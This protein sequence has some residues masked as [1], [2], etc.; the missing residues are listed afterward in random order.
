M[1]FDQIEQHDITILG[2]PRTDPRFVR[3]MEL[4]RSRTRHE[5]RDAID[6][7]IQARDA[8]HSNGVPSEG[9]QFADGRTMRRLMRFVETQIL[10]YMRAGGGATCSNAFDRDECTKLR[11]LI[12][13]AKALSSTMQT[14]NRR[15]MGIIWRL[16]RPCRWPMF[17]GTLLIFMAETAAAAVVVSSMQ[18]PYIADMAGTRA[19]V[20]AHAYQRCLSHFVLWAFQR[21]AAVI[22]NMLVTHA[23]ANFLMRLRNS[24]MR[25]ILSQDRE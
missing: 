11:G 6:Q 14:E 19:E 8:L 12:G 18:L 7:T 2:V 23:K 4:L 9:R 5:L 22:G 20:M 10:V 15:A 13:E 16:Y 17:F 3:G 1:L 21:Q 25:V 24:T